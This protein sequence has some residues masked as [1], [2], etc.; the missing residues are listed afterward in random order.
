MCVVEFVAA[1]K[2]GEEAM[3]EWELLCC[4]GVRPG[5]GE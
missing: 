4:D 1:L 5:V 3:V 2:R